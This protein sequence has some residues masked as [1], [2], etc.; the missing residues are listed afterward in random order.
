MLL[1][2][3]KEHEENE[4]YAFGMKIAVVLG[5]DHSTFYFMEGDLPDGDTISVLFSLYTVTDQAVVLEQGERKDYET[6]ETVP[7]DTLMLPLVTHELLMFSWMP[8]TFCSHKL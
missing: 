6:D 8:V 2:W 5:D 7:F 3:H 4:S 1:L